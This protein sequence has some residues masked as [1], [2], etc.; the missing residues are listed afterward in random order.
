MKNAVSYLTRLEKN[1]KHWQ[2]LYAIGQVDRE[3]ATYITRELRAQ[4]W[5]NEIARAVQGDL[6]ESYKK[7][8]RLKI[9]RG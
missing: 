2:H 5:S 8:F 6:D 9:E 3:T 4:F 7:Q 1:I